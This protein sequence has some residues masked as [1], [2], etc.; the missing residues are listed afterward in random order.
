MSTKDELQLG[1]DEDAVDTRELTALL[2]KHF[3]HKEGLFDL[4]IHFQIGT[5]AF[6]PS[7]AS[8]LPGAMIGVAGVGLKK[9]AKAS[10]NTLDA[11]NLNF[12]PKGRKKLSV[13]KP[14]V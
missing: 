8:L 6:G 9:V 14:K 2:I 12:A 1:Q 5:G 3:G 7:K 13:S 11:S 4:S 10:P